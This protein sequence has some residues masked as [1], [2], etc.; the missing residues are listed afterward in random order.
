MARV[1]EYGWRGR[2]VGGMI[3]RTVRARFRA[4]YL[5]EPVPQLQAPVIFVPNHH[6]WHDGYL[7]FHLI[8]HL[9]IECLDWITEFGAFPW[10]RHVGGMPF[11]RDNAATRAATIRETIRRMGREGKSLVL[12]AEGELHRPPDVWPLGRALEVVMRK[13]PEATV[14]PVAIH[15]DMSLHERP[16]AFLL[17]GNPQSQ[18][19][20]EQIRESLV[21]CLTG[22][23]A[24]VLSNDREFRVIAPGTKDVNERWDMRRKPR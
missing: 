22:L 24:M 14:V 13:V 2:L 6:G 4:V 10:F 17:L 11:P 7:M 19:N 21:E 16:E 3:R 1:N 9:G 8:Q 18:K 12:F 5:A 15:Y 23:R 20:A